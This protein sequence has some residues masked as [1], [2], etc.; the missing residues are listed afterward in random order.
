MHRKIVTSLQEV[1]REA[2]PQWK[3]SR[4][5][6]DTDPEEPKVKFSILSIANQLFRSDEDEA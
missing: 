6:T 3:R 1:K 2:V 4:E 5:D